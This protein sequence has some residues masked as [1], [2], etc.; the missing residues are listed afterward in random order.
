LELFETRRARSSQVH[1]QNGVHICIVIDNITLSS[2]RFL[3]LL[4]GP[5]L[6]SLLFPIAYVIVTFS[7]SLR[8]G[9]LKF[10]N[11]IICTQMC[12]LLFFLQ[13]LRTLSLLT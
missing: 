13:L 6:S 12:L 7:P 5:H 11:F 2:R 10:K 1:L 4:F 9:V 8:S 3:L